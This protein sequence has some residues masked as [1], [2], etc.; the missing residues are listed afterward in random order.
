MCGVTV[1]FVCKLLSNHADFSLSIHVTNSP[2]MCCLHS[3][4][5]SMDF[6]FPYKKGTGIA[7]QLKRS[8]QLCVDLIVRLCAYDP[9]ERLSAKDA[10]RHPY[11][12]DL[13]YF[14]FSSSSSSPP[15]THHEFKTLACHPAGTRREELSL[16][17]GPLPSQQIYRQPSSF[18]TLD[19]TIS[20][21]YV[22]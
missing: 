10:L 1:T 15:W 13:R 9:E 14:L 19:P 22:D 8:S 11:F 6:H 7:N 2:S 16:L 12:K 5:K 21:K 18:R 4:S 20:D 17:A 3:Q